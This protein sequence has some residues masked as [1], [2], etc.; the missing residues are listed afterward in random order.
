MTRRLTCMLVFAAMACTKQSELEQR[1]LASIKATAK[2]PNSITFSNVSVNEQTGVVC[3]EFVGKNS[4][5]A[6][7]GQEAFV[8]Q[9]TPKLESDL[10]FAE[11]DK[12]CVVADSN[13]TKRRDNI[14]A[15]AARKAQ[16]ALDDWVRKGEEAAAK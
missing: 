5:G 13:S 7:A 14:N 1:A 10:D 2:D 11:S 3:G 9:M 8:F 16:A 12:K 15:R 6:Y 4:F